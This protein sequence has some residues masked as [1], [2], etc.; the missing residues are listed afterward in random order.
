MP[1]PLTPAPTNSPIVGTQTITPASAWYTW[2]DLIWRYIQGF[3]TQSDQDQ[4]MQTSVTYIAT[5]TL[6]QTFTVPSRFGVN[7]TLQIIGSG[8]GGWLLQLGTGQT[9][10]GDGD[11]TSG[12]SLASTN[13]YDTV[14]LKGTV[15]DTELAIVA[16]VGTLTYA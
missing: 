14:T 8:A 10:H 5:A 7:D 6:L 15:K 13:R 12:G 2:F 3:Y 16:K 4:T 1:I 11:T 9:I